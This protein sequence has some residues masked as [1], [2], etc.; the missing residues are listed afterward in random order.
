MGRPL[1][2][3]GYFGTEQD[4]LGQRQDQKS[5]DKLSRDILKKNHYLFV[6]KISKK[7]SKKLSLFSFVMNYVL[8]RDGTTC[9]NPVLDCPMAR[10]QA[11]QD[12]KIPSRWKRYS[13]SS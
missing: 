4:I 11:L 7:V 10:F 12:K 13:K 1:A 3:P 8:E 9:Q 5:L 6:K 2:V